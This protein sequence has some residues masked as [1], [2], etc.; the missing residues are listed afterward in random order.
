MPRR[1]VNGMTKETPID[2]QIRWLIRRDMDEVMAIE[3]G[4]FDHP[5][6]EEEFLCC[7]RQRNCI[8]TV[9]ESGRVGST[10]HGFMIYELQKQSLRLLN[11]AVLPDSRRRGVGSQMVQRLV[12]KLEQQQRRTEIFIEIRET[13]VSAQLFFSKRGFRAV[14]V[15]K[16]HYDDTNEDAYLMRYRLGADM[17][18]DSLAI[19][20][21]IG[22]YLILWIIEK[23]FQREPEQKPRPSF[24]GM[25]DALMTNHT[26]IVSISKID[27][28]SISVSIV[29]D[30]TE[31]A[32]QCF[33]NETLEGALSMAIEHKAKTEK[34][35]AGS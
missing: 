14:Q 32:D 27:E 1:Q 24:S 35:K 13:N 25:L 31:Y 17:D 28:T 2:C 33:F 10:V 19:L 4:S 22:V 9:A 18:R 11:F 34:R 8:G 12:D 16:K 21:G 6:T 7:L 3:N 23:R 29:A 5:W 15:L 20:S 26:A 30:W